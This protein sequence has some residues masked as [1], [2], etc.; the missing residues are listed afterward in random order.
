M[1]LTGF[2]VLVLVITLQVVRGMSRD[3]PPAL[4]GESWID[5]PLIEKS[6]LTHNTRAFRFGLRDRQQPL[7]LPIGQHIIIKAI[8]S[9]GNPVSDSI[10]PIQKAYTPIS[11][12]DCKGYVDFV[13]KIYPQGRMT[14]FMDKIKIGDRLQFKGPK[15]RCKNQREFVCL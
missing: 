11:T 6:T 1:I 8:D 14:Q 2:I 7:G 4:D 10:G 13:I 5:L 12:H 9:A 15:V 3:L